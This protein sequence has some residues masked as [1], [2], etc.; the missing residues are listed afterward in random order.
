M[1]IRSVA[2]GQDYMSGHCHVMALAYLTL[3]PDW[4]LR[5][6]IG[7]DEDAESDED[8]RVDHVYVVAP[9]GSAYDCR[10]RFDSESA[11]VGPDETGG[12]ETQFTDYGLDDLKSDV[13][14]GELKSFSRADVKRA[15]NF[16]TRSEPV[17]EAFDQPYRLSW[18]KSEEWGD[19]AY[20]R[21]PDGTYLSIHFNKIEDADRAYQLEFYR[22]YKMAKTGQGDQYRIFASVLKAINQFIRKRKP[23]YIQFMADCDDDPGQSRIKLYSRMVQRYAPTVGYRVKITDRADSVMFEL[24][25]IM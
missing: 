4:Q 24:E 2:E 7:W 11:L 22:N 10:G 20:T 25:R 6:H 17:T 5:A 19:D 3:H 12:V 18:E 1:L 16:I 8:Y 14:R 13:A 15:V 21:L 23:F 9:D